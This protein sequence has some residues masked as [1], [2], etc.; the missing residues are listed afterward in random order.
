MGKEWLKFG[1]DRNSL[2]LCNDKIWTFCQTDL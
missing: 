2:Y 1:E